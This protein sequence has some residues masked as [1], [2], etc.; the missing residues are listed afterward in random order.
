MRSNLNNEGQIIL[1]RQN[2]ERYAGTPSKKRVNVCGGTVST[3]QLVG[4]KRGETSAS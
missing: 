1:E 3:I 2:E 4:E